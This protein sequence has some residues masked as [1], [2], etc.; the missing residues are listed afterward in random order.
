MRDAEASACIGIALNGGGAG[1]AIDVLRKGHVYGFTVSSLAYALP[2]S[3]STNAGC[4]LDTGAATGLVGRVEPLADDPTLT[5]VLYVDC[6]VGIRAATRSG[7]QERCAMGDIAVVAA[8]VGVV[9]PEEAEIFTGIAGVTIT[10]GQAV[11]IIVASGILGLADEDADG[12]ALG[13]RRASPLNGGGAGQAIDVLRKGHVYGFT[14]SGLAYALPVSLS[15]TAGAL[16]DDGTA[17]G[18][19]GRVEALADSDLTKVLYVD[20]GVGKRAAYA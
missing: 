11:Y 20:C 16:L 7:R 12:R 13:L 8:K 17:T 5:K 19:V 9:F 1:Q 14:V 6:G 4:L 2:V 10:A 18:L 15:N 3:L